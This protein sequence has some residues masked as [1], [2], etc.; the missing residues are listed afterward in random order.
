MDA[1]QCI[2]ECRDL[3]NFM[4]TSITGNLVWNVINASSWTSEQMKPEECVIAWCW[5]EFV[6]DHRALQLINM[7]PKMENSLLMAKYILTLFLP[8]VKWEHLHILR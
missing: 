7:V 1:E 6:L 5:Q 3:V 4:T 2:C 8:S